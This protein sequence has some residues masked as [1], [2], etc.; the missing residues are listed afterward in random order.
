MFIFLPKPFFKAEEAR[1]NAVLPGL[2]NA[3]EPFHDL[4]LT[5]GDA[6]NIILAPGRA[7]S[8]KGVSAL[9]PSF[10][11]PCGCD[12][13]SEGVFHCPRSLVFEATGFGLGRERR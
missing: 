8:G 1:G 7:E 11:L 10:R 13:V 3:I 4:V 2:I 12:Q 6:T 9:I 5:F